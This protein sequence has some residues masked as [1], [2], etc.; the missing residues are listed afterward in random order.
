MATRYA[1]NLQDLGSSPRSGKYSILFFNNCSYATLTFRHT[2]F[3]HHPA[4]H[5]SQTTKSEAWIPG[6]HETLVNASYGI[7]KSQQSQ[8]LLGQN[9]QAYTSLFGATPHPGLHFIF[10]SSHFYFC[11]F[12]Y[13]IVLIQLIY[14]FYKI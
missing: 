3:S 10:F 12:I 2:I 6:A 5:V 8:G 11:C 4:M 7:L 13:F 1:C 14:F 9:F